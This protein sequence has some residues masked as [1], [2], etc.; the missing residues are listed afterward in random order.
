MSENSASPFALGRRS[1][2]RLKKAHPDLAAVVALALQ[3]SCV[4]FTVLETLRTEKRQRHLIRQ[5]QSWT[6]NSRHLGKVPKNSPELG[7]IAHAVDLG[8]WVDGTVNWDWEHYFIIAN[9]IKIASEEL[10]VRIKWGG[11]WAYLDRYDTPEQ[12]FKAYIARKKA[13]GEE[14]K[15]DGFHFE[16]C[17]EEYPV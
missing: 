13:E 7:P 4:D 9:A 11:S 10:K 1:K 14:P 2:Q 8:A 15:C 16:L 3:R 17:W 12:G 5:G 6:K